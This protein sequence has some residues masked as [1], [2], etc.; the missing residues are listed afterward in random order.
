VLIVVSIFSIVRECTEDFRRKN[1]EAV[2]GSDPEPIGH[3]SA[4]AFVAYCTK[5][6][7]TSDFYLRFLEFFQRLMTSLSLYPVPCLLNCIANNQS[8][9]SGPVEN[10]IN[11]FES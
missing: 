5:A 2:I 7:E 8:Y 4:A 9:H 3:I 11:S 10:W 1:K 6:Y